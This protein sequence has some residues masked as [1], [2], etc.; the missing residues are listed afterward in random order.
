MLTGL[1]P[2]E[3]VILAARPG[4]GKTSLA[5]NIAMHVAIK[6]TKGVGIF[7]LEMPANQLLMRLLAS[8]A[9]VDMKKLRSGRVTSRD[10]EQFQE[11]A[12]QLYNAKLYIDDTGSL[13][14]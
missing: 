6:E 10:E 5:M 8:A 7:S 9:R 2:G 14:P 12:G 1:H 11:V 3:L 4:V 13:S